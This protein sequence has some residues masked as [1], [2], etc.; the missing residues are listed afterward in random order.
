MRRSG[1]KNALGVGVCGLAVAVAATGCGSASKSSA[2]ACDKKP[3]SITIGATLPL[4]GSGG[5]YGALFKDALQIATDRINASGG[6]NGATL[7]LKVLD[8]KALA[9]PSVQETTQLIKQDGVIAV[10]TA[11]NDPP[12]AQY[13]TG[14]RYKVPILNG[15]GNDPAVL[16]KP[17]LWTN[18]SILTKEAQLSFQ[19]A[20][21]QG[22]KSVGLLAATNYTNFDIA[23]YK[24]IADQVFGAAQ[25]LVTFAADA[26]NVKPQLAQLGAVNPD[27]ISPLSSGL[28]TQMVAKD[29]SQSGPNVPVLGTGS[30]LTEP[31]ILEQKSWDGAVAASPSATPPA[32]LNDAVMKNEKVPA[33]IYHVFYANI[34]YLIKDAVQQ[35]ESKKQCVNGENLNATIEAAAASGKGFAGVA[36]PIV[37]KPDHSAKLAYTINTVK[38]GKITTLKTYP[39]E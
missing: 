14:Q 31:H 27:Y 6:V 3:K 19:Y 23:Q 34:A 5:P 25:K 1:K 18:A 20:K 2:S 24:K 22:A 36:G 35:M 33:N 15:G 21:E 29:M 28:L 9:G 12:L 7:K 11:Y 17:Y 4:T 39:P 16:N 32:W 30:T 37:Y 10:A 13:K 8:S 26:T 38:G